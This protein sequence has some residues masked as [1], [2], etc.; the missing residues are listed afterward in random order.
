MT[1]AMTVANATGE[2]AT[3]FH[4]ITYYEQLAEAGG[5]YDFLQTTMR[6]RFEHDRAFRYQML[7]ILLQRSSIVLPEVECELL[8]ELRD[9]LRVFLSMV[10]QCHST[11]ASP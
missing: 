8:V 2:D 5:L 7:S 11:T 3:A 9:A 10:E 6:E 1:L 4:P